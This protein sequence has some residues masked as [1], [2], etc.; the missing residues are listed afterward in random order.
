M[1]VQQGWG[2]RQGRAGLAGAVRS[3]TVVDPEALG[4][5]LAAQRAGA[6]WLTALLAAADMAAGEED[7]LGLRGEQRQYLGCS[8]TSQP[9]N[10]SRCENLVRHVGSLVPVPPQTARAFKYLQSKS[11]FLQSVLGQVPGY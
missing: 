3:A 4:D 2:R 1:G 10:A 6:Q 5:L 8:H 11:S 9:R 7:H